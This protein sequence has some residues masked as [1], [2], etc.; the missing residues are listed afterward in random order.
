MIEM[1]FE[2]LSCAILASC[3][4]FQPAIAQDSAAPLK[5]GY[6][7]VNA[8][9]SGSPQ[10][11]ASMKSLE[12]TFTARKKAIR[13]KE[14]A[15]AQLQE[16]MQKEGR[17]MD[18]E[19][20]R[21]LEDQIISQ[22]RDV[23]WQKSILED[24]YKRQNNRMMAELENE[25]SKTIAALVKKHGY[26]LVLTQGVILPSARVNLTDDVLAELKNSAGKKK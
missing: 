18:S 6:V 22:D 8:V 14:L 19:A 11:E 16:R 25:I 10:F 9:A 5:I 4:F 2:K 17:T 21:K 13:D 7:D 15:L 24:D 20:L 1:R 26:D 23:R 3:F 12:Q